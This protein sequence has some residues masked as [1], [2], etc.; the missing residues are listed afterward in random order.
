MKFKFGKFQFFGLVLVVILSGVAIWY[1]RNYYKQG[2]IIVAF[3]DSLTRG[4]G[5]VYPDKNYVVFL[6]DYLNIPIINSG[7]T[8]DTT[9]DALI[10]LKED[11]LDKDPNIV[12]LFLGSNDFFV[13]YSAEVVKANLATMIRK[14]NKMGAKI[15]LISATSQIA[16]QYEKVIHEA[17]IE[18]GVFAYIPGILNGILY[19]KDMLYDNIHP[20][21]K[22]HEMIA[23]KILP[24]LRGALNEN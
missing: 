16:A 13:G 1:P 8:G 9:S 7:K 14:I 6:S 17:A 21:E 2:G 20:N 23:Q 10:R 15:I 3:G 4:Y 11:V 19:R 24:A 5:M 18:E 12:V 22:G